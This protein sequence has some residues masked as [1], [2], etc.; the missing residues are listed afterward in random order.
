MK[1]SKTQLYA[2][3]YAGFAACASLLGQATTAEPSALASDQ[4]ATVPE[5]LTPMEWTALHYV[6]AGNRDP[7]LWRR[8]AVLASGAGAG[9]NDEFSVAPSV[10]AK[11]RLEK[12]EQQ[13]GNAYTLAQ[14]VLEGQADLRIDATLKLVRYN[15]ANGCFLTDGVVVTD[16]IV[17]LR[18]P[19]AVLLPPGTTGQW[20]RSVRLLRWDS[21]SALRLTPEHAK[22]LADRVG[23][24]RTVVL[25]IGCRIRPQSNNGKGTVDADIRSVRLADACVPKGRQEFAI[26][27]AKYSRTETDATFGMAL[28]GRTFVGPEV[29]L[30]FGNDFS[31]RIAPPASAYRQANTLKQAL[32][33]A[34][35]QQW[36][37]VGCNLIAIQPQNGMTSCYPIG[38]G[39]AGTGLIVN[40]AVYTEDPQLADS[41]VGAPQTIRLIPL[42]NLRRLVNGGATSSAEDD[43]K[44]R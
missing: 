20:I 11:A 14:H 4:V 39:P 19:V 36:Y 7:E 12:I 41:R 34:R 28:A 10:E 37:I 5:K 15:P 25:E 3:M 38:I 13:A 32:L 2:I 24:E 30:G 33:E 43:R 27:F 35:Q 23:R 42:P 18:G 16:H 8:Y 22:A 26:E 9:A 21:V 40:G 44:T 6:A 29:T 31:V 17:K 1:T